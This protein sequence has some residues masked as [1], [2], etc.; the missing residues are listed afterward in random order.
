MTL[1]RQVPPLCGLQRSLWAWIPTQWQR[2]AADQVLPA[3]PDACRAG[4]GD[5]SPGSQPSIQGDPGKREKLCQPSS[6]VPRQ[7]TSPMNTAVRTREDLMPAACFPS[8]S[9]VE[10]VSGR[11]NWDRV[12]RENRAIREANRNPDSWWVAEPEA[13]RGRGKES[14]VRNRR[15]ARC[16]NTA[17]RGRD[18]CRPCKRMVHTARHA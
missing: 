15:C 10:P 8:Q 6:S 7:S 11:M 18:Y 14:G 5:P 3:A 1:L 16:G 2:S 17:Q 12:N 13:M 9:G 4:A